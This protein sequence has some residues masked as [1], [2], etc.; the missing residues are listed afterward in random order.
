MTRPPLTESC[1][2]YHFIP[3]LS[4]AIGRLAPF[5]RRLFFTV[6]LLLFFTF[7]L[8]LSL[9]IC[10]LFLFDCLV[11]LASI[12]LLLIAFPGHCSL[13]CYYSLNSYSFSFRKWNIISR[14]ETT[15]R[16]IH[17]I[18]AQDCIAFVLNLYIFILLHSTIMWN[19]LFNVCA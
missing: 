7:F 1:F 19:I 11:L 14:R 10:R 18:H 4:F 8:S 17:E 5:V 16:K 6:S 2:I 15:H 3:F 12:I 13:F 9:S